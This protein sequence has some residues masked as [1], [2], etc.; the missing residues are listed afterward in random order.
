M[1]QH[2]QESSY[3]PGSY[4]N[5]TWYW[6]ATLLIY[7][8]ARLVV[9][10]P[11]ANDKSPV[12]PTTANE[13]LGSGAKSPAPLDHESS[14][15]FRC[16]DVNVHCLEVHSR[17][18]GINTTTGWPILPPLIIILV[19]FHLMLQ[20][21][22]SSLA[23]SLSLSLSR[24]AN[25]SMQFGSSSVGDCRMLKGSR[26]NGGVGW[27]CSGSLLYLERWVSWF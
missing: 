20:S 15:V 7:V 26:N 25:V 13:F 1:Q 5:C 2:N 19:M 16:V 22:R 27:T 9:A 12:P 8:A 18:I 6:I 14:L 4:W 11:L 17:A 10:V 23:R 3:E 24:H 21:S